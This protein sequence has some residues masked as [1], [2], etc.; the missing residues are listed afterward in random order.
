MP[1][2]DATPRLALVVLVAGLVLW[3]AILWPLHDA[4]P[5]WVEGMP[6]YVDQLFGVLRRACQP[7]IN[8]IEVLGR[9][10][11][12]QID[13]YQ[14]PLMTYLDVP[15]ARAWLGSLIDDVYAYRYKGIVLLAASGALLYVAMVRVAPPL[16]AALGALVFVTL[17]AVVVTAI[18]DLQYHIPILA[19]VLLIVIAATKYVE[20]RR[21]LW[22]FATAFACG[23]ALLTRAE[24]L[25]WTAA[26]GVAWLLL[27][28]RALPVDWWRNTP[29]KGVLVAGALVA[30]V[31]GGLPVVLMN[32]VYPDYALLHFVFVRGPSRISG[33][34]ELLDV[35][36]ARGYQFV[37]YIL[38]NR[39]GLYDAYARHLPY[40]LVAAACTVAL[41][42]IAI[43]ERRWPF[44]LVALVVVLPLS[45]IANRAPREI[46]LLPLALPVV[47]I[48]IE[49]CGRMR[50]RYGA[51][52]LALV[53]GANLVVGSRVL[54]HWRMLKNNR[55]E[56][57]ATHSCPTCLADA[58]KN[59]A[60]A[61]LLFTNIGLYQ[62][63]RW[64]TRAHTCGEDI[65]G[66][67]GEQAFVR[68][69]KAALA[70]SEP[71]V[72]VGY[73]AAREAKMADRALPRAGALE[74][75]LRSAGADFQR[76][77]V[78][79][80]DGR[81]LYQLTIVGALPSRLV[82]ASGGVNPPAD[83]RITGWVI[84]RGFRPTDTVS[85][86][87]EPVA[88]AYGNPELVTFTIDAARFRGKPEIGVRVVGDDGARSASIR[89]P[90]R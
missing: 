29:R 78:A 87:G 8:A 41:A 27:A 36:A 73:P 43:R 16:V 38:L 76:E 17:P 5:M 74:E 48:V 77:R 70:R 66:W 67:E 22:W 75:V 80:P 89:V 52:V 88:T 37:G 58:L 24:A 9:P 28:R 18:S 23:F 64:A 7:A 15:L 69:V 2:V 90:L 55:I 47:A 56:S 13:P 30:F 4:L 1:N 65:L 61:Q 44:A 40:L 54:D 60:G 19:A 81:T 45:T 71:L 49:V 10:I 20:T 79:G 31:L 82:A 26:A 83:G 68:S 32:L 39:F 14:G 12:L 85:V 11:P 50:L 3:T 57:M 84:G 51:T 25:I 6:A 33:F 86:D 34:G 46:H 72:F 53:V 21:P 42:I 63:A 35:V 59:H 62:E